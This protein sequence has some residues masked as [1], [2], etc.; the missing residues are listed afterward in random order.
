MIYPRNTFPLRQFLCDCAIVR[1]CVVSCSALVF[2]IGC[3]GVQEIPPAPEVEQLYQLQ[4][5][6]NVACNELGRA[7]KD[8]EDLRPR[9]GGQAD[10]PLSPN[11]RLPYVILYGVHLGKG[12]GDPLL[13]YEQQGKNG[14]RRVLTSMGIDAVDEARFREL[15]N[16]KSQP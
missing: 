13:A 3:G 9:M 12:E 15:I 4:S 10:P 2:A 14:Q 6:Y 5:A 8:W 11:D 16:P 1:L 7:P